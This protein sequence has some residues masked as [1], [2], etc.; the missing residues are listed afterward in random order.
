[1]RKEYYELSCKITR[2]A[3][4]G[5]RKAIEQAHRAGLAVPFELGDKVMYRL[6]DGTITD[7]RPE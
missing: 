7:K 1:M 4:R 3:N 6:P 5:A 2:L